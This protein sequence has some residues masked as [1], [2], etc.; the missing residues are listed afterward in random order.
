[1]ANVWMAM[2]AEGIQIPM[3]TLRGWEQNRTRKCLYVSSGIGV[4]LMG[5]FVFQ[6]TAALT[7]YKAEGW[8]MCMGIPLIESTIKQLQGSE[9]MT[10]HSFCSLYSLLYRSL[11]PSV[12][13][14]LFLWLLDYRELPLMKGK[15]T[16]VVLNL[17]TIWYFLIGL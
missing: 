12:S 10:R 3:V 14:S 4:R 17:K 7:F 11:T 9:V 16:Y 8:H 15:A 13:V 2:R 6:Q 5:S 1:M